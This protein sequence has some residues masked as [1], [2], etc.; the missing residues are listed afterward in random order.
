MIER[1][2][3]QTSRQM[4]EAPPNAVFVWPNT[5]LAYPRQLAVHLGRRDL[6]ITSPHYLSNVGGD[7]GMP[8]CRVVLDHAV[9]LVTWQQKVGWRTVWERQQLV[10][11]TTSGKG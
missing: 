9:Q 6:K 5:S 8:W 7:A 3:G 1:G 4:K 2:A 11:E 10:T